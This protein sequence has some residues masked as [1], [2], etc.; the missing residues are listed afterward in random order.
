MHSIFANISLIWSSGGRRSL[1]E[2]RAP[3]AFALAPMR[4]PFS[5]LDEKNKLSVARRIF[6]W[7]VTCLTFLRSKTHHFVGRLLMRD[8]YCNNVKN[9]G[10]IDERHSNGQLKGQR[11]TSSTFRPSTEIRT[12]SSTDIRNCD[13]IKRSLNIKILHR[14]FA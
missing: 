9:K 14:V 4:A 2:S 3:L 10:G 7:R 5:V 1:Y 6:P 12:L 8:L 11:W 13:R